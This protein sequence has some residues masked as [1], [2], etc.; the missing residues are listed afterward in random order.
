M[1]GFF[2]F[3]GKDWFCE[4]IDLSPRCDYLIVSP[5]RRYTSLVTSLVSELFNPVKL[6]DIAVAGAISSL[7]ILAL[8]FVSLLR[9]LTKL[10]PAC[11]PLA[12]IMSA[13]SHLAGSLNV[14]LAWNTL[15]SA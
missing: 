6:S 1:F 8:K 13:P 9:D 11:S 5:S 10:E 12:G 2:F 3:F 4:I 15:G 7:F 14:M